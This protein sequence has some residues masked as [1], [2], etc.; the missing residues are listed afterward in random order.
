MSLL[1]VIGA[2]LCDRLFAEPRRY[3]P[4]NGFAC[5]A[6]W[7]QKKFN[8]RT[9][10]RGVLAVILALL[11][12]CVLVP[13]LSTC[14]AC[15]GLVVLY[16]AIGYQSLLEHVNA[17]ETALL[18]NDLPQARSKLAL[19][20]SRDT[21]ELS[22]DEC[23]QAALE[24]LLENSL[25]ALFASIFWFVVAGPIGVLIHRWVNTLDALWGYKTPIFKQFG[26]AAARLDDV[27]N[28]IP[29]RLLAVLMCLFAGKHYQHAMN[30]WQQQAKHC[31]SPNAGVV[32][33]TGAGALKVR[34]SRRANYHGQW[35][36]KPIM[37]VGP[38]ATSTDIA[39]AKRLVSRCVWGLLIL[40]STVYFLT[41][42]LGI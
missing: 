30:C 14:G 6:N 10:L 3:H 15:V 37:G 33:C 36:I 7:L 29:A 13:I 18:A 11:P 40:W 12:I 41:Y 27:L 17:V 5:W 35:H 21:Q 31:A 42:L 20:V 26:W 32:I 25:D 22:A 38:F 8:N 4:L 39:N 9:R 1:I 16:L 19:I 34:L 23:A 24:T 2:L 28:W